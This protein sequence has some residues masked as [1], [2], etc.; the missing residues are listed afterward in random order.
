MGI[1]PAAINQLQTIADLVQEIHESVKEKV[2]YLP[3]SLWKKIFWNP[4]FKVSII[5]NNID[6]FFFRQSRRR[7]EAA[8]LES[9]MSF[10]SFFARL[11][12]TYVAVRFRSFRIHS[13]MISNVFTTGKSLPIPGEHC[14]WRSYE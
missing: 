13:T 9:S 5:V 3:F 1:E 2:I 7:S 4:K 10:F 14:Q 11:S 8:S 6:I 12:T